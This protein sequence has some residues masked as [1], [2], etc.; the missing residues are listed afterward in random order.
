[1]T[2]N[3]NDGVYSEEVAALVKKGFRYVTIATR[4]ENKGDVLSKHKTRKLAEAAARNRDR[5]IV[6]LSTL[7]PPQK[8]S[9]EWTIRQH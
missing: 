8:G 5:T 6:A 7:T 9:L 2:I 3:I 1:M 4:G